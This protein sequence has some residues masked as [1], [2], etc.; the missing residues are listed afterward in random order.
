MK[1][2]FPKNDEKY[3][4]T[5]HVKDKMLYYGISASLIRRIVRFPKRREEGVAPRTIALMQPTSSGKQEIWVMLQEI[6][7]STIKTQNTNAKL[8]N[9]QQPKIRIIS[10]WRYPGISPMNKP[11]PMPDEIRQELGELLG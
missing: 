1:A 5:E 11:I 9:F 7:K 6:K 10:A 4:W 8:K 2:K 3:Q